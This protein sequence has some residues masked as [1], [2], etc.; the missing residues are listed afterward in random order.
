MTL[1]KDIADDLSEPGSATLGRDI[2]SSRP[3]RRRF[4][5]RTF[6]LPTSHIYRLRIIAFGCLDRDVARRELDLLQ[7]S[8][9][10]MAQ[11]R[12]RAPQ[13][14]GRDGPEAELASVLLYHVANQAFGH[15]LAAAFASPADAT[16]SLAGLEFC[17]PGPI[18]DSRL[19]PA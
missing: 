2:M 17:G 7:L 13:L 5:M 15:P 8:A 14:V 16:E 18:V 9:G 4:A 19:D 6:D 1:P 12:T 11:L 10:S 3:R